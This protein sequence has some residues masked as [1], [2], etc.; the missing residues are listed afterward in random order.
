MGICAGTV[1]QTDD[2]TVCVRFRPSLAGQTADIDTHVDLSFSMQ[3]SCV[4]WDPR[5][6]SVRP[7]CA[8]RV[9]RGEQVLDRVG[10]VYATHGDATCVVDFHDHM[11]YRCNASHLEVVE[12]PNTLEHDF[13]CF[14][15]EL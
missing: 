4:M 9:S 12:A 6:D 7:G 10:V 15:S 3:P 14:V 13:L 5:I 8:V 11:G 2:N 1:V